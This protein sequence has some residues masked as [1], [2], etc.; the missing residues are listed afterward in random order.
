MA[1]V[2]KQLANPTC[3]FCLEAGNSFTKPAG[4]GGANPLYF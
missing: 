1:L 3:L 4:T 2:V